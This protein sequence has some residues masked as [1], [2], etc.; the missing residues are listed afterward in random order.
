MSY[1]RVYHIASVCVCST[2]TQQWNV[3]AATVQQQSVA[4]SVTT[5]SNILRASINSANVMSAISPT[6]SALPVYRVRLSLSLIL[7]RV[8]R[9]SISSTN[10]QP[11]P[12]PGE[13]MDP[14]PNPTHTQPNPHTTNNNQP[15]VEKMQWCAKLQIFTKH[16]YC[17]PTQSYI[18]VVMYATSVCCKSA[19]SDPWR[20]P[21]H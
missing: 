10:T 16:N 3:S 15:G 7:L 2:C 18:H 11:N 9:G 21:T 19:I 5:M 1:P 17:F 8:V 12:L 4:V 14:R 13:F 20:N 6:T